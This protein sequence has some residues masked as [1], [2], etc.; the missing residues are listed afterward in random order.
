MLALP[1]GYDALTY[2]GFRMKKKQKKKGCQ[3]EVLPRTKPRIGKGSVVFFLSAEP[4]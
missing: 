1:Y 2:L 3:I 4:A